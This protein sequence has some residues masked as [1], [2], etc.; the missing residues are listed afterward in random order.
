MGSRP[1]LLCWGFGSVLCALVACGSD[2]DHTKKREDGEAGAGG[3]IA[4]SGGEAGS[5]SV[6]DA[7]SGGSGGADDIADDLGF[8]KEFCERFA[9]TECGAR[10]SCSGVDPSCSSETIE[11]CHMYGR[12]EL[13][14]AIHAGMLEY[15]AEAAEAC[16][17]DPLVGFCSTNNLWFLPSCRQMFHGLTAGEDACYRVYFLGHESDTCAEGYCNAKPGSL[18]CGSGHC[19]PYLTDEEPCIDEQ[20]VRVEP[21]CGPGRLCDFPSKHCA[22][23]KKRHEPCATIGELCNND[24]PRLFCLPKTDGSEALECDAAR[25]SGAVCGLPSGPQ[26]ST[27]CE[28]LVCNAGKCADENEEGNPYCF[29]KTCP[30]GRACLQNADAPTCEEPIAAG[31]PCHSGF[32]ECEAGFACI[33][34]GDPADGMGTC[35]PLAE[36]GESCA[37]SGC[38]NG[39]RCDGEP[40]TCVTIAR[41]GEA[42]TGPGDCAPG[43]SCLPTSMIC[44][45]R[46]LLGES[47]GVDG[48]CERGL[49]CGDDSRCRPW[50][51][52]GEP[53]E[54]PGQCVYYNGCGDDGVC[55]S[56]CTP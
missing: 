33:A 25:A 6:S 34:V 9:E 42:C 38:V 41:A 47:C 1:W 55:A 28:S 22:A 15:D 7:G 39:L 50:R 27:A 21:G 13:L 23:E 8:L 5:E 46:A 37:D 31:E 20:G 40:P 10:A 2:D 14:P 45:A 3:E 29:T 44:G 26:T 17:T 49:Y 18:D 54:R 30:A 4:A 56:Q 43:S 32:A 11:S 12:A 51:R 16:F 36:E 53:C 48:D 35:Q 24:I 52:N 19:L